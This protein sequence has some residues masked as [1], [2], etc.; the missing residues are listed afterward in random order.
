MIAGLVGDET[1]VAQ[2]RQRGVSLQVVHGRHS[3]VGV[4]QQDDAQQVP[5]L[6]TLV[7]QFGAQLLTGG[8]D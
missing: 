6:R 3:G 7:D 2:S 1:G 8:Q 4:D 5:G